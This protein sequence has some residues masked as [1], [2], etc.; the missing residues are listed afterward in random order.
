M[1][2]F[3][4]QLRNLPKFD[5]PFDAY[6]LTAENCDV[7]FASYPDGTDI[8]PHSHDTDNVGVITAG[9]LILIMDGQEHR[10]KPGDW[11]H[12]PAKKVHAARFEQAT[13]EIEFWF[14]AP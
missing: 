12:V 10:F 13:S 7:L 4:P 3:P 9:E 5:G 8:A 14:Q 2:H 11:Y 1:A 6:R